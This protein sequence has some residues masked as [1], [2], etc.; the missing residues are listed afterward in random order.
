MKIFTNHE[1][2]LTCFICGLAIPKGAPV[3]PLVVKH[4]FRRVHPECRLAAQKEARFRT[5]K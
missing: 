4:I 2:N 3:C 1:L 5:K